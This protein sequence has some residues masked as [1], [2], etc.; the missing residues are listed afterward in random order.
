MEIFD[1]PD[2]LC[3]CGFTLAHAFDVAKQ[4]IS[5]AGIDELAKVLEE[6]LDLHN[7]VED[8]PQIS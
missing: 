5:G 8:S 3:V 6:E 7:Y 1:Y 4:V 2:T